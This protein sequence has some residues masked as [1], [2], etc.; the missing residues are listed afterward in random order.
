MRVAAAPFVST[1]VAIPPA[2]FAWV[3]ADAAPAA[4]VVNAAV[5]A[6]AP[7][8]TRQPSCRLVM[9]IVGTSILLEA[10]AGAAAPTGGTTGRKR[11]GAHRAGVPFTAARRYRWRRDGGARTRPSRTARDDSRGRGGMGR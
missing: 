8:P 2:V 3:V 11:M 7:A 1:R 6:K 10:P 5:A 9:V 4:S